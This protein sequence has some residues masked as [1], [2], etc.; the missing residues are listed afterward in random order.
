MLIMFL[1]K[2]EKY[3]SQFKTSLV[4]VLIF[5][6]NGTWR[7]C[8]V[9]AAEVWAP[10]IGWVGYIFNTCILLTLLVN[11]LFK[12]YLHILVIYLTICAVIMFASIIFNLNIVPQIKLP[13]EMPPSCIAVMTWVPAI[14]LLISFP[15]PIPGKAADGGPRGGPLPLMWQTWL[16]FL[17]PDFGLV[18]P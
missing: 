12:F 1:P 15:A 18:Q 10:G 3:A 7:A 2:F 11:A 9:A 17:A 13:F 8:F 14:L 5:N 4:R 6:S 16:G